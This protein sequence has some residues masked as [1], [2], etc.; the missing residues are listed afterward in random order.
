MIGNVQTEPLTDAAAGALEAR[1][2]DLEVL[3][4]MGIRSVVKRRGKDSR[5]WIAF[6]HVDGGE[7]V[8]AAF[9]TVTG[10]KGFYQHKGGR[11]CFWNVD[12]LKDAT[13]RSQAL[14]ITEGHI[15]ALT[16]MTCGLHAVVS[17]CDGAPAH[18]MG[19][20][21]EP[22]RKYSYVLDE[23]DKIGEFQSVVLAVDGDNAGAALLSDLSNIIGPAKCRWIEYPKGCKDLNDVIVQHGQAAVVEIISAARFLPVTGLYTYDDLPP[24]PDWEP[25]R[26]GIEGVDDLWRF[27]PGEVSV[28][29]GVPNHGKTT[30]LNY[31]GVMLAGQANWVICYLSPEQP[32]RRQRENL[33]HCRL[34]QLPRFAG[35]HE[36]QAARNWVRARFLWMWP[37]PDDE[38]T[39]EWMLE[40]IE[41]AFVRHNCRCVIVDPWNDLHHERPMGIE[42]TEYT[43]V[44]LKR[45]RRVA[46]RLG[47]HVIIAAHPRKPAQRGKDGK[48]SPPDGYEIADSAAWVNKPD[49]GVTL[50]RV[51]DNQVEIWTWK[52]RYR[53]ECGQLGRVKLGFNSL[54]QRFVLMDGE[55]SE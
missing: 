5:E 20:D 8:H 29:V 52:V 38:A 27:R 37:G 24:M 2:I 50:H 49:V 33:V 22:K 30:W 32:P 35:E 11:R 34:G 23:L 42:P 6:P 17:V 45:I 43:L 51:E 54:S 9:R 47:V 25:A 12:C 18:A 28:L 46:Q 53:G 39:V 3:D 1:G 16:A 26:C 44:M 19:D 21:D 41:V 7:I 40:R 48:Y 14:V 36:L 10:E 4:R 13:L 15:D 31:L 55:G